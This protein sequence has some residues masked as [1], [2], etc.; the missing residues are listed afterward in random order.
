MPRLGRRLRLQ[1]TKILI[2]AQDFSK[3]VDTAHRLVAMDFVVNMPIE[4]KS[5]I[6]SLKE[7]MR[8]TFSYLVPVS[9]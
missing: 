1:H 8:G 4:F 7:Q 3:V 6:I 9:M 5:Y 2:K